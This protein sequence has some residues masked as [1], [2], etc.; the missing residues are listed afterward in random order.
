MSDDELN[1]LKHF[2][3]SDFEGYDFTGPMRDQ[4]AC[5]SCFLIA[6]NTMLESRIKLWYGEE[7]SLSS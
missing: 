2:D 1:E 7:T 4:K 6:T 3:W 5:G